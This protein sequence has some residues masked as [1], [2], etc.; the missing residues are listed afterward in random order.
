MKAVLIVIVGI[1][2]YLSFFGW[3]GARVLARTIYCWKMSPHCILS[4]RV[5]LKSS[6]LSSVLTC[7]TVLS[8]MMNRYSKLSTSRMCSISVWATYYRNQIW[9]DTAIW[10]CWCSRRWFIFRLLRPS[11]I[12]FYQFLCRSLPFCVS[13]GLF[14]NSRK[15]YP[16]SEWCRS[17]IPRRLD[18][19]WYFECSWWFLCFI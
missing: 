18:F 13:A 14:E 15:F 16:R 8:P 10:D 11:L 9:N 12:L 6:L 3:I 4:L 5:N 7:L 19:Y 1:Y 17:P 2:F